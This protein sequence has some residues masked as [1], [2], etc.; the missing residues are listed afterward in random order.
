MAGLI[1]FFLIHL[2]ILSI[3][4][5]AVHTHDP[6]AAV[7]IFFLAATAVYARAISGGRAWASGHALCFFFCT[8]T[9]SSTSNY[10]LEVV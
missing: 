10:G 1:S 4:E 3:D 8:M 5:A 2:N 6:S 7:A 9:W